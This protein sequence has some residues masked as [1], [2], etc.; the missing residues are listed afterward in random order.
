MMSF[1]S[2]TLFASLLLAGQAMAQA[3]SAQPPSVASPGG[4]AA[5][6]NDTRWATIGAFGTG[7]TQRG[8]GGQAI[9]NGQFATLGDA[10][11]RV[12]VLRAA[13]TSTTATRLTADGLAPSTA[14]TVNIQP[15]G[16]YVMT[17]QVVAFDLTGMA[18]WVVWTF[19]ASALIRGSGSAGYQGTAP[20]SQSAGT[21]ASATIAATGD[22]TNQGLALSFTAP[23][24]NTWRVVARITTTETQ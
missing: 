10:Q 1:R 9:A 18:G 16:Y 14:N 8:Q 23:N 19:P 6:V 17:M 4:Q 13:T 5:S 24:T 15:G 12:V 2:L 7:A 21:G 3:P 11:S 22:T 20:V